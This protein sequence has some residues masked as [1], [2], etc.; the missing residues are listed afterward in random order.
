MKKK[1]LA[2]I[3]FLVNIMFILT[4][5]FGPGALDY[6][7]DVAGDYQ[8]VRSSAH[9]I[10]VTP[11]SGWTEDT[12][13]IPSKVVEIAWDKKFVIAKQQG[14]KRKYPDNPD[15][16]Y[17]EP[18]ENVINYWILDTEKPYGPLNEKEKNLLKPKI[19][20][21]FNKEQFKEQRSLLK[22]PEVLILKDVK[23]YK[24]E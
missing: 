21:P 19:Y 5:C 16:T 1:V 23:S 18:D 20:G 2:L 10:K 22:V 12:P 8:L 17:M 4:G 15:N 11:K 7:Y 14:L 9:E 3:L 24:K 6:S 13:I